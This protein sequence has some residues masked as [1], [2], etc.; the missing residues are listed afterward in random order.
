MID[1]PNLRPFLDDRLMPLGPGRPREEFRARLAALTPSQLFDPTPL[2]RLS[3]AE[4]CQAALWL[5]HDFL[6][7]SH[8]ISQDLPN[9]EGSYWHGIMHRREPDYENSKYWFR[10][11]G[12]HRVMDPLLEE[13]AKLSVGAKGEAAY[14]AAQ[15]QWD[16]V[17]FIDLCQSNAAESAP[18]HLLCRQIQQAEWN[19][20]FEH[21]WREATEE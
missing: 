1:A 7:E 13:A 3:F 15:T 18:Y 19:L 2:V 16:P 11:V 12:H 6:D 14:L 8:R 10:R 9:I 4:A 5:R 20:L 17:R 21:C